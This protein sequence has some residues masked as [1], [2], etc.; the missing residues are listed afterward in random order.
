MLEEETKGNM[1]EKSVEDGDRVY[2]N[3]TDRVTNRY[4]HYSY[5]MLVSLSAEIPV[6]ITMMCMTLI[7]CSGA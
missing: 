4:A 6:G 1:T 7:A 3:P 2:G 5:Y